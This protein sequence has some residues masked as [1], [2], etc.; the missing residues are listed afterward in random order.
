M[1]IF[2]M[3]LPLSTAYLNLNV[4]LDYSLKPAPTSGKT[5]IQCSE[6]IWNEDGEA[7]S[8]K[9]GFFEVKPEHATAL[10]AKYKS[11]AKAR[12]FGERNNQGTYDM[13]LV[14]AQV[15]SGELATA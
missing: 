15:P 4:M 7:V 1:E 2:G 3:L 8:T 9:I 6:T 12:V 14:G 13:V 5:Y 11:G 10:L